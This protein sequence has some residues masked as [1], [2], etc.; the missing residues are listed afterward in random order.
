[1][2]HARRSP[3]LVA[4]GTLAVTLATTSGARAQNATRACEAA[5]QSEAGAFVQRR[6]NPIEA[7]LRGILACREKAKAPQAAACRAKL[8]LPGTGACAVGTLDAGVSTLGTGAAATAV[9]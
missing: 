8:V 6:S 2:H 1:M 3:W 7:C 9:E 4:A 5:I